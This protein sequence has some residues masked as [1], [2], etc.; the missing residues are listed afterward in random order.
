MRSSHT[1]NFPS[2]DG[3]IRARERKETEGGLGVRSEEE[4]EEE[5]KGRL[6]M[7]VF[8]IASLTVEEW[9]LERLQGLRSVY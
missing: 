6:I 1:L 7:K 3:R 9:G 8:Q 2:T 5:R 4:R